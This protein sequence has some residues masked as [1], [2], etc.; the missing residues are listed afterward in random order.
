[1]AELSGRPVARTPPFHARPSR[2]HRARPAE[3]PPNV[4]RWSTT[5]A[6]LRSSLRCRPAAASRGRQ[7][8]PFK[9]VVADRRSSDKADDSVSHQQRPILR[10]RSQLSCAPGRLTGKSAYQPEVGPIDDRHPQ[11]APVRRH[12]LGQLRHEVL[13]RPVLQRVCYRLAPEAAAL[14]A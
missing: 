8:Q 5:A 11:S 13:H 6:R 10:S 4:V 9:R 12:L 7:G 3:R 1:M 2:P 14:A